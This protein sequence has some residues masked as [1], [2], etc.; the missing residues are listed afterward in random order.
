MAN[1]KVEEGRLKKM[2]RSENAGWDFI[3][4]GETYQYKEEGF[5][6]GS[7]I[8]GMVEILEDTSDDEWY[9]FL[10]QVVEGGTALK[11]WGNKPFP[12]AHKKNIGGIYSGMPQFYET[13]EYFMG[14]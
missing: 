13:P 10:V 4:V 8:I 9:R 7:A 5:G 2:A 6:I 12:V 11:A 3:K 1:G 14:D